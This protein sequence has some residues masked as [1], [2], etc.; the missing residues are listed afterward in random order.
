MKKQILSEEF[1]RMQVLAG[2]ITEAQY[3]EKVQ[4]LNEKISYDDIG[5]LIQE[6]QDFAKGVEFVKQHPLLSGV[7]IIKND[8]MTAW[9]EIELEAVS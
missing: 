5:N 1:R 4:M 7:V 2:L 9:G 3:K 8:Q 6:P